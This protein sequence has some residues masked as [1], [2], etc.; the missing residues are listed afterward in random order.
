MAN[1]WYIEFVV[2]NVWDDPDR[3][4]CAIGPFDRFSLYDRRVVIT[5]VIHRNN[6][7]PC[8]TKTSLHLLRLLF[9]LVSID[10]CEDLT[11]AGHIAVL[12]TDIKEVSKMRSFGTITNTLFG[13]DAVISV[14][15]CVNAGCTDTSAGRA[16]RDDQGIDTHTVECRI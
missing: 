15:H 16:A 5:V 2:F 9:W 7:L 10:P 11:Q 12:L 8:F 6:S 1:R 3:H 14:L 4:S 13:D